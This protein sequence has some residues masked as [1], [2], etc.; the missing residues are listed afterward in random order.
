VITEHAVCALPRD[1]AGWRH[2]A[3]RVQ[4]RG[5]TDNWVVKQAGMYV[6]LNGGEPDWV[7]HPGNASQFTEEAALSAAERLAPEI[8][9]GDI[10]VQQAL[11]QSWR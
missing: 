2:Y 11:G 5:A 7:L 8:V 3:L 9:V 10:T 4:R 1:H 6:C